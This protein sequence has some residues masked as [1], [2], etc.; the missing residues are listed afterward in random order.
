MAKHPTQPLELDPNGTL[1]FKE[2]KI[3]SHLLDHGGMDMNYLAVQGFSQE[4]EEQ[5]AQLIGYSLSGFSELSYVSDETL[6]RAQAGERDWLPVDLE[7][8]P[9][10]PVWLLMAGPKHDGDVDVD[11]QPTGYPTGETEYRVILGD[12]YH[13]SEEGP[14]VELVLNEDGEAVNGTYDEAF[15]PIAFRPLDVPNAPAVPADVAG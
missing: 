9:E 5:F 10:G 1:R 14:H 12:L 4:D 6:D 2:N 3:V 13:D 7:H 11:G 8:P 15:R